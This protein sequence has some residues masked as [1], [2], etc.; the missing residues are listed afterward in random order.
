MADPHF[1]IAVVDAAG[2]LINAGDLTNVAV[3]VNVVADG[4]KNQYILEGDYDASGNMIYVG[5]ALP[6][7]ATNAPSWQIRRLDYSITGNLIDVLFAN[8]SRAFDQLWTTR[9]GLAY[10]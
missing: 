3:R 2:N 7:S 8:G 4:S 5:M 10:S 6:G 1:V 9:G